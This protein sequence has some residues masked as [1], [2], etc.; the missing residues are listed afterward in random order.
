MLAISRIEATHEQHREQRHRDLHDARGG[1]DLVRVLLAVADLVDR[2]VDHR[3]AAGRR[4]RRQRVADLGDVV[5]LVGIDPE[6]VGQRVGAQQV[7]VLAAA[8]LALGGDRLLLR[9]V[10]HAR[11]VRRLVLDD[12]PHALDLGRARARL[13]VDVGDHARA[14]LVGGAGGGL[15]DRDEDAEHEHGHEHRRHGGERRHRVARERPHR[16]VEEE[17]EPHVEYPPVASSR[18]TWPSASSIT[19]RRM[20]STIALSWVATIDRRPRAVDAV[21]QLHD[22]D[23]GLGVEVAGRLV[24]QQQRRVVDERA[25][26]RDALLLAAGELV[27]EVVQLRREPGQAQDVRHLLADLAAGAARHLQGVGDVVVHRAVGQQLEVLEDHADVAAVVRDLLARHLA[28]VVPRHRDRAERRLGLLDQQ[29]HQRRLA[30][31]GRADDE[32]EL[33]GLDRERDVLDA[34]RGL[35]VALGD[36]AQVDDRPLDRGRQD[37]AAGR[38]SGAAWAIRRWLPSRRRRVPRRLRRPGKKP[39]TALG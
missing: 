39:C 33:A 17:A 2:G 18:I 12:R 36:R 5:R 3:A 23:R 15:H 34:D 38:R 16:L 21:E 24:G 31:A 7:V 32:H 29:P 9:D 20:R 14:H 37:A 1:E 11:H 4:E 35:R 27:G 26:H 22:P 10:L 30:R 13:Q 8:R 19:R 25:R 28:E 6:R